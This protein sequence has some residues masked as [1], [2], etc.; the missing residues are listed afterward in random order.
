MVRGATDI[1]LVAAASMPCAAA[2]DAHAGAPGRGRGSGQ[3]RP[4]EGR[5]PAHIGG[6]DALSLG[7]AIVVLVAGVSVLPVEMKEQ[8]SKTGC[9]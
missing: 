5:F 3:D 8:K 1:L 7:V 6:G 4:C 9:K 2:L